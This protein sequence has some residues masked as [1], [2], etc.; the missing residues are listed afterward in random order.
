MNVLSAA[1]HRSEYSRALLRINTV[2]FAAYGLAYL[3]A[4]DSLAALLTGAPFAT[5]TASIDGRAIYGGTSLG[6]AVMIWLAS[7]SDASAQRTAQAGCAAVFGGLALGRIV[8]MIAGHVAPPLMLALALGEL[9]FCA[10]SWYAIV[11][12]ARTR[13]SAGADDSPNWIVRDD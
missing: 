11:T 12:L 6:I 7:G 3:C 1:A 9:A 13:A 4:P 8:G 10:L 2:L 5:A